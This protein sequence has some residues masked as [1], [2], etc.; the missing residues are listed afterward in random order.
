MVLT[1]K[2]VVVYA[3]QIVMDMSNYAQL[4]QTLKTMIID[5][6]GKSEKILYM[7]LAEHDLL[8]GYELVQLSKLGKSYV[9]TKLNDLSEWGLIN[10]FTDPKSGKKLYKFIQ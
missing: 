9:Y 5:S 1:T 4:K 2:Q 10:I 6:L 7:L 3:N 8:Y